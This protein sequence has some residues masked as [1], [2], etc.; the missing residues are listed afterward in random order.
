MHSLKL[1]IL[2][3][4]LITI[5]THVGHAQ[6]L[7]AQVNTCKPCSSTAEC[8]AGQVCINELDTST[9]PTWEWTINELSQ[10]PENYYLTGWDQFEYSN[11]KTLRAVAN[12][13]VYTRNIVNGKWDPWLELEQFTCGTACGEGNLIYGINVME[14]NGVITF[15]LVRSRGIYS[16]S[17][18]AS[19]YSS[20]IAYILNQQAGWIN[21]STSL[22]GVQNL[23]PQT[24]AYTG[25]D[26]NVDHLGNINQTIVKYDINN[27]EPYIYKRTFVNNKWTAW[28]RNLIGVDP[29]SGTDILVYSLARPIIV[30]GVDDY[31]S[32]S[33]KRYVYKIIGYSTKG[34]EVFRKVYPAENKKG[35][36][37]LPTATTIP[38]GPVQP[39]KCQVDNKSMSFY[40]KKAVGIATNQPLFYTQEDIHKSAELLAQA[41]VKYVRRGLRWHVTEMK[42]GEFWWETKENGRGMF[43]SA[44]QIF[45]TK[46]I[47]VLGVLTGTPQW[48]STMPESTNSS[49]YPAEDITAWE[50]FIA[51]TVERYGSQP[52][53][54][55]QV[56]NWEIWNEPNY[57]EFFM[58]DS[59]EYI[60]L[61]NAAYIT[62]HKID[63]KVKVWGPSALLPYINTTTG[64]SDF[65]FIDN[66][67]KNGKF[68]VFSVHIYA[69]IADQ[70]MYVKTLRQKLDQAG[71]KHIPIAI[72]E[73]NLKI[74]K[75][76][77]YCTTDADQSEILKQT[78]ACLY[79]AGAQSVFWF[80]TKDH[81]GESDCQYTGGVNKHGILNTNLEPKE[82]YTMLS[83]IGNFLY[84]E[85][86]PTV[87]GTSIKR[88]SIREKIGFI[89]VGLFR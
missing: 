34:I 4:V 25:F 37:K 63:P 44:A 78:Y 72:T 45:K 39:L 5:L 84:K 10:I 83:T 17:F 36:C 2:G 24:Y 35:M 89:L 22:L 51:K 47:E 1:L 55:N 32:P 54:K 52:G 49:K 76:Y 65:E 58:G 31:Y 77:P 48:A 18:A 8:S 7:P 14:R 68:D 60:R 71:K 27:I 16:K 80:S 30:F 20:N 9:N 64:E 23:E 21:V 40:N 46:G 85:A 43:D 38:C 69:D 87:K 26:A 56:T 88:N 13:R 50:N 67:I 74:G 6:I 3:F 75:E 53:G 81:V 29:K 73:T 41:K 15:H 59:N 82:S 33:T 42:R 19:N 86:V 57:P 12:G 66:V 11:Y 70:H 79:S 61:L 62:A 28:K